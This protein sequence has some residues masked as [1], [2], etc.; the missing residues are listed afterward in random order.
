[1]QK[2]KVFESIFLNCL[3]FERQ[4]QLFFIVSIFFVYFRGRRIYTS[5]WAKNPKTRYFEKQLCILLSGNKESVC[6]FSQV[7]QICPN[8]SK[9]N[10]TLFKFLICLDQFPLTIRQQTLHF[11]FSVCHRQC[12]FPFFAD[13]VLDLCH[14]EKCLSK[15][16]VYPHRY[17]VY[18][19]RSV[20][21]F[22]FNKCLHYKRFSS[23]FPK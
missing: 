15:S 1:M 5:V 2:L 3:V 11:L 6:K 19:S 23:C 18:F 12:I 22:F 14:I 10:K 20:V 7:N 21:L 17:F 4:T 9:Q 13:S 8:H 16:S